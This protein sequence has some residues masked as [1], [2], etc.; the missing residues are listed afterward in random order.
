MI[1]RFVIPQIS[2]ATSMEKKKAFG[3]V[4]HA[5]NIGITGLFFPHGRFDLPCEYLRYF[6]VISLEFH[7]AE[8]VVVKPLQVKRRCCQ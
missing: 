2:S 1:L 6:L 3:R 4:I 8:K 5:E 7:N